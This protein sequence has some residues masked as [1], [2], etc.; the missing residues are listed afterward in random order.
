MVPALINFP[1]HCGHDRKNFDCSNMQFG[2]ILFWR[3]FLGYKSCLASTMATPISAAALPL[4]G[5]AEY[6]CHAVVNSSTISSLPISVALSTNVSIN[7]WMTGGGA[8]MLAYSHWITTS[9][10]TLWLVMRTGSR[11]G[12][13]LL[14][15]FLVIQISCTSG[16]GTVSI[17]TISPLYVM[18]DRYF[19]SLLAG[20]YSTSKYSLPLPK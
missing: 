16:N 9:S 10:T 11:A 1:L 8:A 2:Q 7:A 6:A 13:L 5:F 20:T 12:S 17:T 18:L 19:S 15:D 3:H 4:P 14:G